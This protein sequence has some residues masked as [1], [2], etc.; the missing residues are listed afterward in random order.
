MKS[1][2]FKIKAMTERVVQQDHSERA[3]YGGS[4]LWECCM[5]TIPELRVKEAKSF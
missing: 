5:K 4:G 2:I 3:V 1:E